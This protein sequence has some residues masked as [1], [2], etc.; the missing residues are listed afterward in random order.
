MVA[1]KRGDTWDLRLVVV[2]LP[3][4]NQLSSIQ[5]CA[6]LETVQNNAPAVTGAS[7][8]ATPEPHKERGSP[9]EESCAMQ[10]S[11]TIDASPFGRAMTDGERT[12][13]GIRKAEGKRVMLK[14]TART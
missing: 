1:L 10:Q 13:E 7:N 11:I 9:T 6:R 5:A 8:P 3:I 14:R 2:V 12:I 4:G